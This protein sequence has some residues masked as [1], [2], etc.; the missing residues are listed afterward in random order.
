VDKHL[1]EL[2][3]KFA[4]DPAVILRIKREY[5]R[6]GMPMPHHLLI[7]YVDYAYGHTDLSIKIVTYIENLFN[8][9]ESII[10]EIFL[11]EDVI[12]MFYYT[13]WTG[14]FRTNQPLLRRRG[15]QPEFSWAL[16][17]KD[18]T[19]PDISYVNDF[20]GGEAFGNLGILCDEL[21]ENIRQHTGCQE[22]EV[23]WSHGQSVEPN[24][25]YE[26]AHGPQQGLTFYS[27]T[28]SFYIWFTH[29]VNQHMVDQIEDTAAE[30][31]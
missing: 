1:R 5:H 6:I 24:Y 16:A 15:Y 21:Q 26:R 29:P 4:N 25:S 13:G 10:P 12:D 2:Y 19:D 8:D 27:N 18:S 28:H 31:D 7:D 30:E 17:C 11:G 3:R 23:R 14:E 9:V 20:E 22:W